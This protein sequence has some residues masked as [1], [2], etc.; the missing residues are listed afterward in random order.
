MSNVVAASVRPGDKRGPVVASLDRWLLASL[1]AVLG[2]ADAWLLIHKLSGQPPFIDFLTMWTGGRIAE[3]VPARLYDL[4]TI[5][6]AQAWLLG[7]LV[8]DRPFPYPPTALLVFGPLGRL[9]FPVASGV[10][11]IGTLTAFGVA[12]F[13]LSP[14][15]PLMTGGLILLTPAVVWA[16]LSGQCT[17]LIGGLAIPAVT[18]LR[19]RPRLA[20]ALL[21]MAAAFKPTVLIMAPVV[22]LAEGQW[23]ALAAAGVAGLGLAGLSALAYGPATWIAWF[24]M[25]G[26]YLTH[27]TH[28]PQFS[29][30]IVAPAG[31]AAQIGLQGAALTLWKAAFCAAGALIA[32]AVVWRTPAIAPRLTALFGA[33][34]LA[35]PYAMNYETALMAPGAV[36]T[37]LTAGDAGARR[38]ATAALAAL[39]AAGI[40]VICGPALIL[41]LG[42]SLGPVLLGAP[43][44]SEWKPRLT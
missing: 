15:R 8:H 43:T 37:L 13:R 21:G 29:T 25:S 4:A 26:G 9:P 20:G 19:R 30:A 16:T 1:V 39:A 22:L 40:P 17:F 2:A 6:Q 38:W 10:W 41:F 7:P 35:S 24:A 44:G 42:L 36:L 5:N 33:S 14:S 34:L 32:I 27:I 11:M 12:A 31:M 3:T 23:L 28:N 18:L